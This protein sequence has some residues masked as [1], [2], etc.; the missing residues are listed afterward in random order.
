MAGLL[1]ALNLRLL[2]RP[3]GLWRRVRAVVDDVLVPTFAVLATWQIVVVSVAAGIGE[4]LFDVLAFHYLGA[5]ARR[6]EKLG[7]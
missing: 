3:A 1:A 2:H 6:Q 7:A 5:E 4:E